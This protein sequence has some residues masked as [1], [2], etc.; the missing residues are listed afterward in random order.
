MSAPTLAAP[1]FPAPALD[2]PAPHA[3]PLDPPLAPP[4]L[5]ETD[6]SAVR[7]YSRAFPA[8]F[9]S[10]K[11]DLL[12]TADGARYID[13]LSGAGTLNYGHN[14]DPIKEELLAYLQ[15]DGLVHGLDLATS[16]KSA[17][18]GA[19][20]E[21]ILEP[22]GLEYK[23]Q[24]TSPS[25]TNA[26]EAALK[27]A[28]LVTGR[29]NVVAFGG[30]FHGVSTGALAATGSGYYRQGLEATL[31]KVTHLPYPISPLGEFDSIGLLRHYLEDPSSG[32]EKPA[33]VLLE[34]VQGEG[35]VW[36]APTAFLRE[37]RALCDQY[38]ILLVVD[39]IQAGC[40]RTGDFFSF[41]RAGITPDLV[42]LSKSIGGYG[43]PMAIVLIKPEYDIWQPGQHNGTFRGHQLAFVAATA[44]LRHYWSDDTFVKQVRTRAHLVSDFLDRHVAQ[45]YGATVR[46]IGLMQAVDLSTAPA[47]D[48]SAV[49]RRCFEK[50]LVIETCGRRDEVLKLL[51]PLTISQVN[52][53]AGLHTL[54]DAL[55]ELSELSD[56]SAPHPL[57]GRRG[58]ASEPA[59]NEVTAA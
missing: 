47:L 29:T 7:S 24:F 27:V 11:G 12:R 31:P 5:P 43:L 26:V 55:S 38:G 6:E 51:P 52:L 42:T 40:G 21:L 33:A 17:F 10:A 36:V 46:G 18:L 50:G 58:T 19:L 2:A 59:P 32:V 16:A 20:R 3:T 30:G 34:T 1:A 35:G 25:G 13:F 53:S 39:D 37:L 45:P 15:N 23:V 56:L 41:E 4:A 14:P 9:T 54:A 49:S 48:A 44:A 8:V 57:T 28:R 22:R